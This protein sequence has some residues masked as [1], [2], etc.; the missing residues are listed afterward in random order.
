MT[1]EAIKRIEGSKI[2]EHLVTSSDRNSM[3]LRFIKPSKCFY[4]DQMG[5]WLR[6]S[7]LLKEHKNSTSQLNPDT[8]K[9]SFYNYSVG[10]MKKRK[11]F[12]F[13]DKI[14]D[15]KTLHSFDPS[16][17]FT[18]QELQKQFLAC[19]DKFA[20]ILAREYCDLKRNMSEEE[21]DFSIF[22][23]F[24]NVKATLLKEWQEQIISRKDAFLKSGDPIQFDIRSKKNID[25]LME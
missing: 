10:M 13:S 14:K 1:E 18:H 4:N 9:K 19:V 11:E 6:F 7:C 22:A 16:K 24:N 3:N 21:E 15:T 17:T 8:L 12:V 25:D 23:F 20:E 2:G 5:S